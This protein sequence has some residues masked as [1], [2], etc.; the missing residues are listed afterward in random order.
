VSQTFKISNKQ[1]AFIRKIIRKSFEVCQ[2]K[3]IDYHRHNL[4]KVSVR[5]QFSFNSLRIH[6][7]I[8]RDDFLNSWEVTDLKWSFQAYYEHLWRGSQLLSKTGERGRKKI[9][10]L[11]QHFIRK[12]KWISIPNWEK[13]WSVFLFLV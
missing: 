1:Q 2:R 11:K 9:E 12:F 6:L 8:Y 5:T 3:F 7:F 4:Y 10:N 13:T